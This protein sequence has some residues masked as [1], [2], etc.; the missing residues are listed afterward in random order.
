MS[1]S[2]R[3]GIAVLIAA[4]APATVFWVLGDSAGAGGIAFFVSF[5]WIVCLGLPAFLYLRHRALVRWWSAAFTGFLQGAL[6]CALVTWPYRPAQGNGYSVGDGHKMVAY[7]VNG[8]PTR[9]GWI[10]YLY[11][12]A[13]AGLLGAFTALVFWLAWRSLEYWKPTRTPPGEN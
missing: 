3:V 12:C 1:S 9:E 4:L 13:Q 7:V 8:I 11:A 2:L 10:N 5:A 6:P